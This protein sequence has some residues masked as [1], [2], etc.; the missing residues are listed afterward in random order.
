MEHVRPARGNQPEEPSLAALSSGATLLIWG[1]RQWLVSVRERR[2]VKGAL[3]IP[4]HR[5]ACVGAIYHL[6]A[7]MRC[8]TEGAERK[9]RIRC[10]HHGRLSD[11]EQ[12]L[13]LLVRAEQQGIEPAARRQASALVRTDGEGALRKAAAAYAHQL[14]QAGLSVSSPPHLETISGGAS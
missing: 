9:I 10:P 12:R 2:C 14:Q 4:H 13:L 1:L 6:D 7:L 11:D 8:L 5:M 3:L